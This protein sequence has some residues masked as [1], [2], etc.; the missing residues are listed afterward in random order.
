MGRFASWYVRSTVTL[1]CTF[2][3]ADGP[4]CEPRKA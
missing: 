3:Y 4:L 1:I 2:A